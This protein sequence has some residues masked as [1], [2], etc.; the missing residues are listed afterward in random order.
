[1]LKVYNMYYNFKLI[2][3]IKQNNIFTFGMT[4]HLQRWSNSSVDLKNQNWI[5]FLLLLSNSIILFLLLHIKTIVVNKIQINY[6]LFIIFQLLFFS[7]ALPLVVHRYW[8]TYYW[9]TYNCNLLQVQI[10]WFK[11]KVYILF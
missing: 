8:I 6:Y 5:T 3:I 7:Y 2:T 1:M 9:C 10:T 4:V 11:K